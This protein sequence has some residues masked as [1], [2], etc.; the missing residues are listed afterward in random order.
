MA[1]KSKATSVPGVS[2]TDRG[3]YWVHYGKSLGVYETMAEAKTVIE[4]FTKSVEPFLPQV[5][6]EKKEK[7]AK[8]AKKPKAQKKAK[9]KTARKSEGTKKSEQYAG[10]AHAIAAA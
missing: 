9:A 5:K 7:K 6:A 4:K 8:A 3:T 10:E 2:K 1:G